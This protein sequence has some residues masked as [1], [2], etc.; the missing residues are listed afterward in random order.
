MFRLADWPIRRKLSLLTACGAFVALLLACL[1]FAVNDVRR[2]RVHQAKQLS[3]LANILGSNAAAA[4]EFS[5]P[6]VAAEVLASLRLQPSMELAALYDAEG[7]LLATYPSK[8]PA[9]RPAPPSPGDARAAAANKRHTAIVQ[10]IRRHGDRIG[11]IYLLSNLKEIGK[12]LA[13]TVWIALGVMALALGISMLI[14]GW[15]QRFFTAPIHELAKVMKHVAAGGDYSAQ[16][17][18][19]GRDELGVLCD[20]FNTM[21]GHI[22]VTRGELQ[23]AHDEL[24]ERVVE[25]TAELQVA[26]EAAQASSRA[27]G[28]FLANMSHEIRTPMTAILGYLDLVAAECQQE[29][30]VSEREIDDY[31]EVIRRNGDHLLRIIND[32]LDVS[33]IED[34]KMTVERIECSLHQL[35][36]EVASSMRQRA[37]DK[38][39][40]LNVLYDGRVPERIRT[41]PTRLHQILV[42]LIGNAVK[43][44]ENGGICIAV[45]MVE[46]ASGGKA[47]LRFEITDTGI[48]MA[49]EQ[50]QTVFKPFT[51]ADETM[52]RRFGGTGLGLT[53]SKRL[54]E[55]LGGCIQA[56]SRQGEGSTFIL[57][58]DPGSLDGVPMLDAP[59]RT[60]AEEQ[61]PEETAQDQTLSGRVLLAEDG[62]DNQRLIAFLLRKA[63]LEVDLAENGKIACD[64]ALASRAEGRPYDLILMDIQM[65][66]LNGYEATRYLRQH[67]WQSPIVALTAHAMTTDRQK[68]LEVGCDDYMAKPIDHKELISLVARHASRQEPSEVGNSSRQGRKGDITDICA[69][70]RRE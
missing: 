69:G 22:E 42:N 31:I 66:Q 30:D 45:S 24:E 52:S 10:D 5:Q 4:I 3:A 19:R 32:I 12:Q 67:G 57:T 43:F 50:L 55:L 21:L 70:R 44:T 37:A 6:D 7:R 49:P 1:A 26:L 51:Q 54:A 29:S 17:E 64:K 63:G 39:L 28:D 38:G 13:Q 20:G 46:A 23:Q 68:C 27:K 2:I 33:K 53:I 40:R 65:P 11:T 47:L 35:V 41:D 8:P 48:G 36:A 59:Q 62:P 61:K 14:T 58:V 56:E 34:G 9:D 15:L 18:K 25:R 60:S 16:V